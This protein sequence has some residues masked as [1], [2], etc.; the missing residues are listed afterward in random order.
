MPEQR[1]RAPRE[2]PL[3]QQKPELIPLPEEPSGPRVSAVLVAYNQV[4]ALR[5]AIAALERSAGRERLEILVVDS[6]SQDE[7]P[8]LDAEFPA[9]QILRLPQHFGATRALNIATRTAKAELL[10]FLSPFVE[11]APDTVNR[12]AAQLDPESNPDAQS[13]AAVCPLI[14]DELGKPVEQAWRIPTREQLGSGTLSAISIDPDQEFVPVDFASR[15]ALMVP[16][17][18]IRLMNNFDER[19]GEHWADLD[20]AMQIRRA[21]KRIRVYPAIHVTRHP[22]EDPLEGDAIAEADRINGAAEFLAKYGG[23]FAGFSFR[24][25]AILKALFSF[26]FRRLGLLLSGEKMGSQAGR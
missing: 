24:F 9:V 1:S 12:L 18:F 20:L 13:L 19:F 26:D 23:F 14:V 8:Q 22:G 6:G 17:Q 3:T 21:G 4:D 16:K 11:V 2:L 25:A 15:D 7:S 10:L 5:R